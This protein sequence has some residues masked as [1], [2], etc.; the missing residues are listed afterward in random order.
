MNKEL[1][2]SAIKEGTVIDHI[3]KDAAFKVAD[4]LDLGNY[5]NVITIA[6]NLKSKKSGKKGIIK[7]GSKT[8][9][10]E[11][12]SKIAV[13]APN[14]TVNL[15]H[16][17]DVKEKILVEIPENI[18]KIIRCSNPDC[19]TNNED[20]DTKFKVV[21]KEPLKVKCHYCERCMKKEEIDLL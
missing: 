4:I 8:L 1:K 10:K 18:D 16:N 19:I 12:V 21:I 14:A 15:I 20:V 2:I 17:Y 7:I 11:E 5:D 9:T 3:P 13:I 6:N